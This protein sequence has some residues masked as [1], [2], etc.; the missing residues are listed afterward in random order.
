VSSYTTLLS[1][2]GLQGL[3]NSLLFQ[4]LT[5]RL[6]WKMELSMPGLGFHIL[7]SVLTGMYYLLEEVAASGVILLCNSLAE[8]ADLPAAGLACQGL[9]RL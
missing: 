7:C 1:R 9:L 6:I 3:E 2:E 5:R 4:L 8:G